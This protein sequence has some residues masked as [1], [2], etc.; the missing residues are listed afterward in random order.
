MPGSETLPGI[1]VSYV[2]QD[3]TMNRQLLAAMAI[4]GAASLVQGKAR[5]NFLLMNVNSFH[6]GEVS[7]RAGERWLGLVQNGA[8]FSWKYFPVEV[9]AL[10]DPLLDEEGGKTGTEVKVSGGEPVFLV[11]G[12]DQLAF[13]KVKT[14]RCNSLGL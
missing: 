10:K 4:L 11:R 3:G 1:F 6:K 9:Q 13:K 12:A 5:P 2:H 14:A 7:A 8:E